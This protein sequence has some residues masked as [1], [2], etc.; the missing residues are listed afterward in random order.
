[1]RFGGQLKP[2]EHFELRLIR[3]MPDLVFGLGGIPRR[4][5]FC[6][7]RLKFNRVHLCLDGCVYKT[8]RHIKTAVMVNSR[9]GDYKASSRTDSMIANYD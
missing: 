4:K 9:L 7:K 6:P 1:M 5:R 3:V 2:A 8:N